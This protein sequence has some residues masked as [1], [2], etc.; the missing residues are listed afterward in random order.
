M[1]SKKELEKQ[2]RKENILMEEMI[3]TQECIAEVLYA[4]DY[5]GYH[6]L[7]VSYGIHPCAY[8]EIPKGHRWYEKDYSN[9]E[10]ENIECHGGLTY[11]GKLSK[12]FSNDESNQRWFI[13]WD[14]AHIGDFDGYCLKETWGR[15]DFLN[16]KRWTTQEI[17]E[18][19]KNVIEQIIK[20]DG[21]KINSDKM[22]ECK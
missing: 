10:L 14:Y 1:T 6:F 21:Q 2:L 19:V 3:Y 9:K 16:V 8:V 12:I 7:I 11:S 15:E 17:F 5:L 20:M 18:E 4:G 22:R 13:G